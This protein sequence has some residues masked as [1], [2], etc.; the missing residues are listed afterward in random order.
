M[1]RTYYSKIH[2]Q[3][4]R[5]LPEDPVP[6]RSRGPHHKRPSARGKFHSAATREQP[7]RTRIPEK[8]FPLTR[9]HFAIIKCLHHKQMLSKDL[10]QSLRIRANYLSQAIRPAFAD[11]FFKSEIEECT[12]LWC[13]SVLLAL[14]SHYEATLNDAL[15]HIA[16]EAIPH[17]LLSASISLV[18][19]W[20]FKQ[21]GKK[22]EHTL[23]DDAISLINKHQL[24]LR[25]TEDDLSYSSKSCLHP[26][27]AAVAVDKTTCS[28]MNSLHG[29]QLPQPV[30]IDA[31][32]QTDPLSDDTEIILG[33][34]IT[35]QPPT[36]ARHKPTEPKL[37][38]PPA[39]TPTRKRTYS[40]ANFEVDL[41]L[42]PEIGVVFNQPD[43]AAATENS[44]PT[45]NPST[46][47]QLTLH[48]TTLKESSAASGLL[49]FTG[50]HVIFGDGN[51]S[52]FNVEKTTIFCPRNGRLSHLKNTLQDV[53]HTFTNIKN[54][55]LCLSPLDKENQPKTNYSCLRTIL[56]CAQKVFPEARL[57]VLL[58]PLAENDTISNAY[59]TNELIKRHKPA[60]CLVLEPPFRS[61]TDS[62]YWGNVYSAQILNLLKNHLN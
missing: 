36:P 25:E 30:M 23:L 50:E 19:K 37:T 20:T 16:A 39:A 55:I 51:L 44:A 29:P 49:E 24:L 28:Q 45:A 54:F 6:H 47:S 52:D 22:I 8:F 41:D 35:S 7:S 57:S 46:S 53:S 62:V 14:R 13:Q 2:L 58:N 48:G 5:H 3:P 18:T 42:T 40:K 26:E 61:C 9:S 31:T 43:T 33:Q 56:Y 17:N 60:S 10:P 59:E 21:I 32:A 11:D 1:A 38:K 34:K 15:E 12:E 4:K 27:E